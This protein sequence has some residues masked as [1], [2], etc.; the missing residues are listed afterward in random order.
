LEEIFTS[1]EANHPNDWLLSV[2]IAELAQKMKNEILVN[3]VLDH[4]EKV[5][6]KRPDIAH[7]ITNGLELLFDQSSA[8]IE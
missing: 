1:L 7:L 5:K 2:E 6:N 4:L 3:K 8:S